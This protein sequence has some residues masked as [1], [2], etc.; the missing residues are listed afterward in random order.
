MKPPSATTDPKAF[1]NLLEAGQPAGEVTTVNSFLL[2]IK[3]LHPVSVGAPIVLEDGSRGLVRRVREDHV[4]V[5]HLGDT[6]ATAGMLAV[7]ESETLITKVGEQF[8]GRVI[9]IEGKPLDGGEPIQANVEWPVFEKA[10][11]I[12]ERQ[13]LDDLL[14]TG[15]TVID[16]LF[17]IVRGQRLAILGD[18]KTGKSTLA[19]Q[20]AINQKNT[21]IITVYVMIA[22]NATDVDNLLSRLN[23]NGALKNTIVIVSTIDEALGKCYVAPYVGCAMAEYLW[24]VKNKDVLIVYDDLT[25][26]A[27]I[28]REIAL[29]GGA[30]PGRDSYPGDA[31]FIHSSLLERAGRLRRNHKT[32]TALPLVL[33]MG[34]DITA[35]LP[36][37][38]ISITDGQWILDMDVFRDGRRPAVSTG[39]SVT[40]VGGRGHNS[41]QKS[42]ADK[43]QKAIAEYEQALEFSH[44]G[45]DLSAE[46]RH[47]LVIGEAI[48]MLFKQLPGETYTLTAQQLML[49]TVLD[50]QIG[51]SVGIAAL[52]KAIEPIAAK[53]IDDK[54]YEK[55]KKSL[56]DKFINKSK[57]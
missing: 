13:Q 31:F 14:V 28:H 15:V 49:D 1:R 37:N 42:Q 16:A 48:K 10:P 17:P 35:Y 41:R 32:L 38:I 34:G 6:P 53:I 18:S 23:E 30:N 52:K 21:D 51:E 12:H 20:L 46:S 25:T 43:V 5:L 54:T 39:L 40:R 44:F 4:V 11:K 56:A 29:V 50:L 2:R 22:K 7:V 55:A 57:A 8:I 19:T 45:S 26:H 9:T 3:G 24:Q 33:A 47:A 36:T 27:Q